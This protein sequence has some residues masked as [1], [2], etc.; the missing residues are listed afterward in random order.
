MVELT[1]CV[2]TIVSILKNSSTGIGTTGYTITDDDAS[3]LTIADGEI[4][5]SYSLSKEELKNLFGGSQ[6][7][8]IIITVKSGEITDEWIGLSTKQWKVPVIIEVNVIDKWSTVGAAKKYI[9]GTLVRYKAV[10]ALRKFIK[11][12]VNSPGGT[13]NLWKAVSFR[14]EE[15]K[16]VKPT[17]YKCIITTEAWTY[18][19]P[20]TGHTLTLTS[21][22]DDGSSTNQG[23]I[24]LGETEYSLANA[25]G[26]VAAGTEYVATYT[27]IGNKP[28][29][30]WSIDGGLSIS[31]TTTNPATV[32]VNGSGTLRANYASSPTWAES[33][34]YVG[35][36]SSPGEVVRVAL[37]TFTRTDA[38]A[39]A[40]GE[41]IVRSLAISG[42]YLYA[43]LQTSPG[44]IVKIDL[45]TFTR[46][47]TLTLGAGK[48][49][50]YALAVEGEFLYAGLGI[51][52]GKIIKIDLTTFEEDST[53]SLVSGEAEVLDMAVSGNYLYGA[54][55]SSPGKIVKVDLTAFTKIS[56][57][58][59][60]SGSNNPYRIAISGGGLYA[61]TQT[62]PGRIVKVDLESFAV[63]KTIVLESGENRCYGITAFG[64]YVYAG[65]DTSP[66]K[67][68]KMS[69]RPF[70]K[71]A[72]LT[73]SLAYASSLIGLG[74]YLYAGMAGSPGKIVRITLAT[75]TEKDTLS[76]STGEDWA[77]VLRITES[78]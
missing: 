33:T 67:V 42:N 44:K 39:L 12:K 1:S 37:D 77:W 2:Q 28:F 21:K 14:D 8:D 4:L 18:Y 52:P 9:T 25:V 22:A 3:G 64:N 75:F 6:D 5:V 68:I 15:D 53:L 20:N 55:Y 38:I 59:L 71:V 23:T 76:L 78:G 69:V 61:G 40:S 72:T 16:T 51:D 70:A 34:L 74:D 45:T 35:S 29:A 30:S 65:T 32:T 46:T 7:Y 49:K 31:S 57:L 11:A 66:G 43:G 24:T 54:L 26:D 17:I 10:N 73:L 56:T 60:G 41:N 47:A 58:S 19:N 63:E 50:V 36:Y 13:I 27:P 48:N 62:T